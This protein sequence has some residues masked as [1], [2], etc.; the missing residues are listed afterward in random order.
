MR[1]LIVIPAYNEAEN[2]ERTLRELQEAAPGYDA[3]VVNDGSTDETAALCRRMGVR[4]LDLPDNLGIAGAVQTG[5]RYACRHGYDAVLQFDADGQHDP[6]YIP[7]LVAKQE[8]TQADLVIGSRF[9][10]GKRSGSLRM[11]GNAL[12]SFAIRATTGQR[13]SDSTSGMRLYGPK[14]LQPMAYGVNLGPEPD[15]VAYFL[16][17]GAKVAE[18]PV[19]MRPR[20]AGKSYLGLGQSVFYMLHMC[21]NIWCIQWVRKRRDFTCR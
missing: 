16:R 3:V 14:L 21:M 2:I 17:S 10:H 15:T 4:V 8:E 1:T 9:L 20:T 19:V 18:V 12:L 11:W 5:M 6:R 7:Q 13:I